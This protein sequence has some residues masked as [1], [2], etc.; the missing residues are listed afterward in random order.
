MSKKRKLLTQAKTELSK[1]ER[2]MANQAA[3]KVKLAL[4]ESP[5]TQ[6]RLLDTQDTLRASIIVANASKY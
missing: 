5:Y 4:N 6:S 3:D 1:I 2:M